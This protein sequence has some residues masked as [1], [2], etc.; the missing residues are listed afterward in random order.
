[1]KKKWIA[2]AALDVFEKEPL[3]SK[4]QLLKMNNVV[5]APHIGSAS[6]ETREKMA[7]VAAMNLYNVLNGKRPLFTV[8]PQTLNF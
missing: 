1:L 4:S 3:S 2:G 6:T 8:N 5:L 7:E